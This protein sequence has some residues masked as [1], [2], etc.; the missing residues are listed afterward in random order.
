MN[1]LELKV[2]PVVLLLIIALMM[3]GTAELFMSFSFSFFAPTFVALLIAFS[4]VMFALL[5]VYQFR[6]QGTTVDP[7]IPE[8][9]ASLVTSGVYQFSRNPMYVGMLLMLVGWG[10]YLGNIASFIMLPVFILYMNRFQIMPE[11]MF[12]A[13]KFGLAYQQYQKSVR[14]WL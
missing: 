14:R 1:K 10:I 11:E 5:G 6:K 3:W 12:M 9:S 4:G 13:E 2:P 7:R 8:K